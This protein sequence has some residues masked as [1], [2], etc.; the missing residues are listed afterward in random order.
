MAPFDD[1]PRSLH[2]GHWTISSSSSASS[3]ATHIVS[4]TL[5]G[6]ALG[7]AV[8]GPVGAVIGGIVGIAVSTGT[9]VR[10]KREPPDASKHVG[11]SLDG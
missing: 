4:G 9:E 3:T 2:L 5:G 10:I 8:L 1:A 7:G 6:L 11:G